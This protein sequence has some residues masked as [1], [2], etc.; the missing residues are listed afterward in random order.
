[1][2]N[3]NLHPG[4]SA[5]SARRSDPSASV[6]TTAP[7]CHLGPSCHLVGDLVAGEPLEIAGRFEGQLKAVGQDV[8]VGPTAR[9]EATIEAAVVSVEGQVRGTVIGRER[10]S[11]TK[12]ANMVG[13]LA[14]IEIRV[15]EG[16][17]FRGQ[18]DYLGDKSSTDS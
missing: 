16:A 14:T 8:T 9:V 11:L 7:N 5:Q 6:S 2:R 3:Q 18:V 10:A 17:I 15:E 12:S 4:R 1:M 13:K